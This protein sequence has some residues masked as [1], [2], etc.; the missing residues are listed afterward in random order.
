M[1]D[2]VIGIITGV[3][4]S[5]VFNPCEKA[6]YLQIM[7]NKHFL[8]KKLWFP[9]KSFTK[10]LTYLYNGSCISITNKIISSG[11]YFTLLDKL[12]NMSKHVSSTHENQKLITSSILGV[13]TG[14]TTNPLNII[15]HY[16]WVNNNTNV[17][18]CIVKI[19]KSKKCYGFT[20]GLSYV[21]LRD[22]IF[23]YCYI[24][25]NK[26]NELL[27]NMFVNASILTLVSPLNYIKNYKYYNVTL[28][29]NDNSLDIMKKLFHN[30]KTKNNMKCKCV[31]LCNQLLI[32]YGTIISSC[33]ITFS[34][35]TY[36]YLSNK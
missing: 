29:K 24:S 10:N 1:F 27:Y 4:S 9:Y 17:R 30:L 7:N 3:L 2:F 23:N 25:Y 16:S 15:K 11:I 19:Y 34:Q 8:D 36:N 12:K 33:R 14:I 22:V 13:L 20:Y 5:V 18:N 21:I 31:Y 6:L 35:V 28:S 32:G 26:K